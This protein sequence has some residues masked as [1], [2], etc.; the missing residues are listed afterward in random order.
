[1]TVIRVLAFCIL[2]MG[3]SSPVFAGVYPVE[4]V[5]VGGDNNLGESTFEACDS[6]AG[7]FDSNGDKC[8]DD[9]AARC[10]VA[11]VP[12][13]RCTRG[14]GPC[15]WPQGAGA[16]VVDPNDPSG[17]AHA[18]LV[19]CLPD[20]PADRNQTSGSYASTLCPGWGM[21]DM[22]TNDPSCDCQGDDPTQS[23]WEG[24]VCS[25]S[26][27]QTRQ[28]YCSDGGTTGAQVTGQVA[29]PGLTIGAFS[30]ALCTTISLFG[31]EAGATFSN[32]GYSSNFPGTIDTPLYGVENPGVVFTPQRKPGTGLALPTQPIR[33]VRI[34]AASQIDDVGTGDFAQWGIR[35]GGL[36]SD[37]YYPDVSYGSGQTNDSALDNSIVTY[38]CD[39][40]EGWTPESPVAGI[41]TDGVTGCIADAQC[42][43]THTCDPN[44]LE[45][46]HTFGID[47]Q[48]F[49]FTRDLT[50]TELSGAGKLGVCPPDCG[51][52]V[53][54]D[55]FEFEA[56][57][58]VGTPKTSA[59]PRASVQLALDNLEGPRA[60]KGDFISV[61]PTTSITWLTPDPRCYIG[62]DPFAKLGECN[63]CAD[64]PN[65]SL[66]CCAPA[67]LGSSTGD[68]RCSP[69]GGP[70]GDA[71]C[72]AKVGRCALDRRPCNP[73][74]GGASECGSGNDCHFCG[75]VYD[76]V[77]GVVAGVSGPYVDCP[78]CEDAVNGNGLALPVG[79]NTHGFSELDL[80]AHDRIFIINTEISAVKNS[81]LLIWTNSAA[82]TDFY[83][84]DCDADGAGNDRCQLGESDGGNSG[85]G[86]GGSFT[87]A[88]TPTFDPS[89]APYGYNVSWGPADP[90]TII[91]VQS[92][93]DV[94]PGPD[95]IQGCIG[96]NTG[97]G[98]KSPCDQRLGNA[99]D[100]GSTGTDDQPVIVD[101]SV[102]QDGSDLR[103]ASIAQWKVADPFADQPVYNMVTAVSQRDLDLLGLTNNDDISVK[104][105]LTYCPIVGSL[106]DCTRH[107]LCHDRNGDTDGDFVCDDDDN[108]A[109]IANAGQL[110]S[111]GDNVGDDCDNCVQTANPPATYPANRTTSG[112]QLDD[113]YDGYGNLCDGK[114]T[115]GPI[116]TALDTIQYKGAINKPLAGSN[117][118]SPATKP[119]DQFDLDGASPVVTAL[120]TIRFKQL[121]NLP[122]GPKCVACP[123]A[124]VGDACP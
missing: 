41:C 34:S 31:T 72:L 91:S 68:A 28:L 80:V 75:G 5:F 113:D 124:C 97:V 52:L 106:P 81:L 111:D 96:D 12:E 119:C 37:S 23:D 13:G 92:V 4:Q 57:L 84:S 109:D 36:F 20:S 38:L 26:P 43:A 103:P 121:L 39:P 16:C 33:R 7:C 117:C 17:T 99:S 1:M 44:T 83:D 69:V 64:D 15:I 46:C 73:T 18:P 45:F 11:S 78:G 60:G 79:Y 21:C 3:L 104:V 114:F 100:P 58:N 63:P 107:E 51:T 89:G 123:L 59:D 115:G 118:G 76:G 108:C 94:G 48:N 54:L 70:A 101:F 86:T 56:A 116:V 65:S 19:G 9:P 66:G 110:D 49:L 24:A 30:T 22:A 42:P 105:T 47:S 95:G 25:L 88:Q 120:D 77:G 29:A 35:R 112:G 10:N 8:S 102:A 62:G 14:T 122:V 32:C 67:G 61:S 90:G 93:Y 53:D 6:V 2:A 74:I 82:R 71:Q 55:T 98:Y 40:P 87:T 85:I 50:T 27:N